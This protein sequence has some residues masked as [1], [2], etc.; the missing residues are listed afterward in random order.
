MKIILGSQSQNRKIIL[1]E[2]G[3]DF[4]VMPSNIDEKAIRFDNPKE[5]VLA[6]AR[7]KND[8]L[9]PK[10]KE[11]AILI[12]SDQVVVWNGEIREKPENAEEAKEFL[13]SYAE[14]PAETVT[15]VVVTNLATGQQ[16]EGVDVAKVYFNPFSDEEIE[17]IIA[18]GRTFTL[19]GGFT[20]DGE[21]WEKHIKKI[22]GTRDSV[23]GL[24][25]ALT[26]KLMDE[27]SK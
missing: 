17:D 4:E 27:V 23:M 22:D 12:T 13:E 1:Q 2:M 24:P 15:A 11:P 7:A 3:L 18:D 6:L 25:K 9:R 5:L 14:I 20:T 8:A 26:K 16:A 19:A 21:D 10:I